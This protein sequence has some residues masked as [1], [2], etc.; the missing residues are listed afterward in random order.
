MNKKNI[1]TIGGGTGH[2]VLLSGLKKYD[3]DITAIVSMADDGGSTGVLRDEMGVLP[4]GDV[5]QCL[6]ALSEESEMLRDLFSYR[7]ENGTLS[8]HTFGNLFLSAL[9]KINGNF[10]DGVKEASKILRVRGVVMPVTEY[11]MR[12]VVT[13]KDGSNVDGERALDGDVRISEIGVDYISLKKKVRAYRPALEAI[14]NA[15][16][17]IIGPGDL[18]GSV[19]PN[20][21]IPELSSAVKKSDAKVL[22]VANLTNKKGQTSGFS[23]EYYVHAIE[24][25]IGEG[26]INTIIA[27][28]ELPDAT[29]V[30]DYE[31]QEGPGTI[32]TCDNISKIG[33]ANVICQPL[34][35]HKEVRLSSS[36]KIKKHR[37]FIRHDSKKLAKVVIDNLAE[38]MGLEPT[39]A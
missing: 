39:W 11:Q 16:F 31:E 5:R 15:D 28:S 14:K 34:L 13:L 2:F 18:Y 19:L 32:V 35:S 21:L 23:I 6:V 29:A 25:C 22:Y 30:R 10:V 9:E 37:S 12:L 17:I 3:I 4:P 20:F 33:D 8:G 36:D 1:V 26:R 7:F 38:G 24:Q 27:N